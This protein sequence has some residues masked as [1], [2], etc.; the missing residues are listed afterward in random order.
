[1]SFRRVEIDK[2]HQKEVLAYRRRWCSREMRNLLL[3]FDTSNLS[4]SDLGNVLELLALAIH[5]HHPTVLSRAALLRAALNALFTAVADQTLTPPKNAS[6]GGFGRW[7]RQ[8]CP[9]P[10]FGDGPL[11]LHL[12]WLIQQHMTP[13][14][15]ATLQNALVLEQ[16][17]QWAEDRVLALNQEWYLDLLLQ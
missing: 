5:S 8:T 13:A 2:L 15:R 6:L 11:L 7:L 1:M 4:V 3:L 14:L 12:R 9:A 16:D 10:P 17:L